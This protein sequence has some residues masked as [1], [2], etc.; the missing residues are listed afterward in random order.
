MPVMSAPQ[1][2]MQQQ[3]AIQ[4]HQQYSIRYSHSSQYNS[5]SNSQSKHIS[6]YSSI[7]K[8]SKGYSSGPQNNAANKHHSGKPHSA[9][10]LHSSG[11]CRHQ[12]QPQRLGEKAA[13]HLPV[14]KP[15]SPSH[16]QKIQP[17]LN[18]STS[19][20]FQTCHKMSVAMSTPQF[21]PV[22]ETSTTHPDHPASG[23]Q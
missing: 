13:H 5:S 9:P 6:R 17:Q 16:H 20:T 23:D 4:P 12:L 18:T 7:N 10:L 3:Q 2:P 11:A 14:H 21:Q 15:D 22:D 19:A 1:Q 8:L